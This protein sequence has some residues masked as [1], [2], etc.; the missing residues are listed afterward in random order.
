MTT[1]KVRDQPRR[2]IQSTSAAVPSYS[3]RIHSRGTRK[4]SSW[5]HSLLTAFHKASTVIRSTVARVE[6]GFAVFAEIP[7]QDDSVPQDPSQL[8]NE[9][10]AE[11]GIQSD[12]R[13]VRRIARLS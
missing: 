13:G 8:L 3:L 5:R 10:E 1:W 12:N 11:C 2:G 9:F 6:R 4:L 7:Y